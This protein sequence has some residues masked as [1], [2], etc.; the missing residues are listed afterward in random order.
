M[1]TTAFLAI[2]MAVGCSVGKARELSAKFDA[3]LLYNGH[4]IALALV[5]NLKI[6]FVIEVT[7][8]TSN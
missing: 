3:G 7:N 1:L 4:N 2:N 6:C 5:I 8:I